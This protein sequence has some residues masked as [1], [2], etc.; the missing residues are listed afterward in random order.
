M[1]LDAVGHETG[2]LS[3]YAFQAKA[4]A[5]DS[6]GREAMEDGYITPAKFNDLVIAPVKEH[7]R[8][9]RAALATYIRTGNTLA[10]A[11]P[12]VFTIDA[13]PDVPRTITWAFVSHLQI[14]AFT[15]VIVGV[16]AKGAAQTVT[17]A[18]ASGWT[19]ETTVAFATITSITLTARTGTGA[20]DTI[21]VG[22]GS[23]LGLAMGIAAT[24]DVFKVSKAP[25]ASG[26]ATDYSGVAN[27]TPA[28]AGDIVD[29][30]TGAA[31]V[32]GDDFTIS[33]FTK[34]NEL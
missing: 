10:G 6:V 15:I 17:I 31:I 5:N 25:L 8:G 9:V 22:I 3:K 11:T 30:S 20:G 32:D 21:N 27:V 23:G 4:L 26:I 28:I 13:Q 16:N 2:W 12:V 33:Y 24:S 29:V 1:P 18:T 14:T 19:G 34:A 7:F